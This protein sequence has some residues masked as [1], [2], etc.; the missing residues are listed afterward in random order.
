MEFNEFLDEIVDRLPDYLLIYDIEKIHVETFEKNNG[1]KCTGVIICLQNDN[2]SPSIYMEY[3][4]SL[5]VNG[6]SIEDILLMIS[7]EYSLA[8]KRIQEE[9]F[10]ILN[11]NMKDKIFMRIVNYDKNKSMLHNCPHIP[12]LD[13]AITFRYLVKQDEEGIASAIINYNELNRLGI[14]E[15]ELFD[16]AKKNT[17]VLFP[18]RL[19][20]MHKMLREMTGAYVPDDIPLFVLTNSRC[21]NGATSILYDRALQAAAE[22]I[23]S[24]F[25]VLPSSIHEVLLLPMDEFADEE[26]LHLLVE[27]VNT[28][29]LEDMDFLSNSVY[30]YDIIDKKL[31]IV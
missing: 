16:L 19:E 31:S 13:M 5:Y 27:Q 7:K 24:N 15:E 8:R 9:Q 10:D 26:H 14:D 28:N 2:I 25:Y 17:E 4:Y 30:R 21:I 3:Y 18:Y 20:T 12:Y 6:R 22:E 29:V 1:V 11:E 23:G